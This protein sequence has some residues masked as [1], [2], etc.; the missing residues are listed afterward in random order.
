MWLYFAAVW[1]QVDKNYSPD[2]LGVI[3]WLQV[4]KNYSPV[5]RLGV[6]DWL[7]S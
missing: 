1:L 7:D 5:D 2:R 3:D 6:I 4:D